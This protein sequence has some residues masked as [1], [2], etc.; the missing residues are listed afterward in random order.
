MCLPTLPKPCPCPLRRRYVRRQILKRRDEVAAG[1]LGLTSNDEEDA[2][3][4][5]WVGWGGVDGGLLAA[6][7]RGRGARRAPFACPHTPPTLLIDGYLRPLSRA[8]LGHRL[9]GQLPRLLHPPRLRLRC[10][11]HA[12]A[13]G[14]GQRRWRADGQ[15]TRSSGPAAAAPRRR[16]TL[17]RAAGGW[18]GR[19]WL[20]CRRGLLQLL[21]G[22]PLRAM[23]SFP[24]PRPPP[25][26]T[27][28][29]GVGHVPMEECAAQLNDLL[30]DW[31]RQAVL[32][33]DAV[34][35]Q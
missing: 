33:E 21:A 9:A 13:A 31:V 19:A 10:A 3:Q 12:R 25:P 5:G 29:Q 16:H 17:C 7:L 14:A 27:C 30:A 35:A 8:L 6:L 23:L 28:L 2:P 15:H 11:P 1:R 4:V 18:D 22:V 26:L 24:N 20:G 32:A 34:P